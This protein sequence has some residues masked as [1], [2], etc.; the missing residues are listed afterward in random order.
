[1]RC[2]SG[3]VSNGGRSR[4]LG[5]RPAIDYSLIRWVALTR[6]LDDGDLPID[7]NWVEN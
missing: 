2:T 5:H 1:M 6:F 3:C 7:N 4:T